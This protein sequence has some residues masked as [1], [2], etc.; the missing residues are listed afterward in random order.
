MIATPSIPIFL[1]VAGPFEAIQYVGTP[2]T[3]VAFVVAVLAWVYRSRL[4]ERRKLIE[5]APAEDRAAMMEA[6]I[7]D[8]STIPL[9]NLTKDQR[10]QLA[11]KLIDERRDRFRVTAIAAAVAAVALVVVILVSG[12]SATAAPLVVR[13]HGPGGPGDLIREGTVLLDAGGVRLSAP[14]GPDGQ[15]RFDN[16]TP[17]AYAHGV[18]VMPEVPGFEAVTA[19][20]L[21][22]PPDGGAVYVAMR[23]RATTV[24]GTVL[25]DTTERLPL[26]G[27]VVDFAAGAAVDTTDGQGHF[28]VVLPQPPGSRVPVRL[29]HDGRV[30]LD[31]AVTI[32]ADQELVLRF[33]AGGG[34]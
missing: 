9:E 10:Y 12:G 13:L 27:V 8:F 23:P 25:S 20:T 22:A 33:A 32:A 7:R 21:A 28:Q 14:V 3:L 34:S 30:G 29:I 16:L 4:A 18:A 1:A 31:D 24:R 26:A 6:A 17:T 2:L 19:T 11:I 15:A 5:T